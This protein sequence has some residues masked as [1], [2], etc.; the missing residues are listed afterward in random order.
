[1]VPGPP[2]RC[3]AGRC[4]Q[5]EAEGRISAL[6]TSITDSEEQRVALQSKLQAAS[7]EQARSSNTLYVKLRPC[8]S[9]RIQGLLVFAWP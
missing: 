6:E 9:F 4:K 2:V 3:D 5:G 8:K 7:D 1:M